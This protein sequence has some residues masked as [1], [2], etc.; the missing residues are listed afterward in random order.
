MK[1]F[2]AI[3]TTLDS[4]HNE[5]IKSFKHNDEVV[6]PKHLKQIEKL[7]LL[8]NKSK[9]KLEILDNINKHKNFL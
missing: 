8:L 6:I 4:K 3:K 2:N 7:E 1:K 9:N 5:I